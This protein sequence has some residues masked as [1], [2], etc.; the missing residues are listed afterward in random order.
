M[1]RVLEQSR[2]SK[3]KVYSLHEPEVNCIAKGKAHKKC[4]PRNGVTTKAKRL[5]GRKAGCGMLAKTNLVVGVASF[6]DNLYDGDTLAKT[7]SSAYVHSG[8]IFRSG[9][10]DRGY[11]GQTQVGL[12]E[13]VQPYRL[14]ES[15]RNAYQKRKH[16]KRMNRRSAIEPIIGHLKEDHRMA[17]CYLKGYLGSCLNAYMAAAAWNFK[18]KMRELSFWLFFR[19]LNR[20]FCQIWQEI[21]REG[22]KLSFKTQYV[23]NPS[24]SF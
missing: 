9:L 18:M 16:R 6:K 21:L 1:E 14:C 24:V 11:K 7:L 5:W 20:S 22:R 2:Y 8:K 19:R 3:N 12:T 10:V 23:L 4:V 13:V 17:R 15:N